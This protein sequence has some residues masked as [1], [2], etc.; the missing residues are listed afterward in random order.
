M[1]IFKKEI[2]RYPIGIWTALIALSLIFLA[3]L[4][5]AYSLLD[6]EGAVKL[7]LQNASFTGDD[8]ERALADVERG[9]AIADILWAF[10]IS[11]IAFI[12]LLR[13]RFIGFVAS[14]MVFAV[15]VYFPLLYAFRDSTN[16]D[17]VLVVLFLWA[18]PSLLGII[19][20]WT[21]RKIF[22]N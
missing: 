9:I 8:A 13:N 17:I 21:N 18:T 19:G 12:G 20:L 2:G 1:N 6:W 15:C 3:W 22:L 11:I 10:P 14:M 7:G 5:Q 16:T 4:M